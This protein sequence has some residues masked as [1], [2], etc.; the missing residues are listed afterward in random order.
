MRQLLF[1]VFLL[2]G[3]A[4]ATSVTPE[5]DKLVMEG[6]DA[7]YRM[8][9]DA[10]D[11]AAAK[12]MALQP[13]YP[14]AH[15][16][17]AAT[18]LMRFIYGSEASDP[19]KLKGFQPKVD[20][21]VAVSEAWLKKHP[22]DSDVLM[23]LGSAH[24]IT[25]RLALVRRDWL[26]AFSHGRKSM[27]YIR[28]AI[29]ADPRQY[30]AYLGVGMF[31]YYV[32]TIPRF[33]GWL[34][35]IMLGGDRAR[36]LE[37][38]KVAAEKGHYA[39]TAAQLI[40]VEVHTEDDF[41]ARNPPEALRLMRGIW[42]QYPHSSMLHSAFIVALYEDQHYDEARKEAE[43][44]LRRVADGRYAAWNQP[45]GHALLGTVNW[46]AGEKEKALADFRAGAVTPAGVLRTR[47]A[48]WSK[49]RAG[50]LLDAL[51]RRDEAL[52][53]YKSALEEHKL[54]DFKAIVKPCLAKPCLAG[55]PGHFSPSY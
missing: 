8:D 23:V 24:G 52:A 18:E 38:I 31:D 27:K 22:K 54:W 5:M 35:K 49:V 19:S 44:Y 45:K 16:G 20:K 46:A 3:P 53:A 11:R 25:S 48:V 43:E 4:G 55:L 9:F 15:M 13:D 40:L 34:A 32:D 37:Q 47:W 6:I 7:L 41:G 30:D 14:H 17:A 51:G 21:V 28:A 2:A 12:A 42:A 33:A 36:G 1:A 26:S 10:A 39:K 50:Q 29:K